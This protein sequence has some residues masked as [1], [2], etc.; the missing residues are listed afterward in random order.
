MNRRFDKEDAR[1]TK[2]A[3]AK[4]HSASH[5]VGKGRRVPSTRLFESADPNLG[6]ESELFRDLDRR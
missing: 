5:V 3:R 4:E 1:A 2:R 6:D